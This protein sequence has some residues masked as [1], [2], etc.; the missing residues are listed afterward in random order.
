MW[1]DDN[2][3]GV[4]SEVEKLKGMSKVGGSSNY[5]RHEN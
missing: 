4:S 1:I 5:I 3:V 2:D